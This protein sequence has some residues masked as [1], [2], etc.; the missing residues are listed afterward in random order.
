MATVEQSKR[1]AKM[2]PA[3]TRWVAIEGGNHVQFGW[4]G[5]QPGDRAATISRE[6]QQEIVVEETAELLAKVS[7]A[8][9]R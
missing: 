1:N 2:L 5:P 8:G 3:T 4:Y 9:T 7:S 6:R